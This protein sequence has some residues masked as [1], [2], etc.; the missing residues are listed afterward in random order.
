VEHDDPPAITFYE[1][2]NAGLETLR[3][4]LIIW[5]LLVMTYLGMRRSAKVMTT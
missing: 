1:F 2:Q 3:I 5:I 4:A